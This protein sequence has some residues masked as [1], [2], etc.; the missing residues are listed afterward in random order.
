MIDS[1]L[2]QLRSSLPFVEPISQFQLLELF[3]KEDYVGMVKLVRDHMRLDLRVRVGL[4][5]NRGGGDDAPAWVSAPTPMPQY[6]SAEFKQTVVTVFL[7]KS[8]LQRSPFQRVVMAVAHELS[9]IVL[10]GIGHILQET[11]EAV[12]LA[13]MLLGYR[14]IYFAGSN[15]VERHPKI[16]GSLGYLTPEEVRYASVLL[17]RPCFQKSMAEVLNRFGIFGVLRRL[18]EAFDR[19]G[20][21]AV[22]R[23]PSNE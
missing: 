7:R 14:D 4:V 23:P 19:L 16:Y 9:H 22:L 1:Y 20:I 5:N 15:L 10:L 13:A 12:D 3:E 6:G 2:A 18:L 11:E 17:G 21:S 8:F